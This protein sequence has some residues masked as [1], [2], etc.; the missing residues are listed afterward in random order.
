MVRKLVTVFNT[1]EFSDDEYDLNDGNCLIKCSRCDN[2]VDA[3][4]RHS[5][6]FA[7]DCFVCGA[8]Q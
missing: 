1:W 8:K 3:E 5:K 2:M 4:I 7:D 6:V